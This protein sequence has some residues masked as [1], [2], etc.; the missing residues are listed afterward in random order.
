MLEF[1]NDLFNFGT[2]LKTNV[3]ENEDAYI[4]QILMP[5]VNKEDI[6]IEVED[7]NLKV[8]VKASDGASGDDKYLIHEFAT[9]SAQR[10]F[11]LGE[12]DEDGIK[13]KLVDGVLT[14][15]A[16]KKAPEESKKKV[17]DI[18]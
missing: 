14:I 1:I 5:G 4:L 7:E 15:I 16:N 18:L 10:S 2:S 9:P 3:F 8:S 12:I 6:D 17:I 13:A 11:Y